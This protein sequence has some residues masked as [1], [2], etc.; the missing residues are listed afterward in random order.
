[1]A[2]RSSV[3]VTGT[4][5]TISNIHAFDHDTRERFRVSTR[6][7]GQATRDRAVQVA[8]KETGYMARNIKV[9]YSPDEFVFDVFCDPADYLPN[10]LQF[11]PF[12]VHMGT[13]KVRARPFLNQ[14][15]EW[16]RRQYAADI[17]ADVRHAMR[18][19]GK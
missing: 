19:A 2:K 7:N 1:M 17:R 6:K 18:S 9:A 3:Q 8:P 14:A 12:F 11:Y 13:S 4:K 16:N 5:A 15:F 10:G